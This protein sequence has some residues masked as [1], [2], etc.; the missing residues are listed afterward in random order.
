MEELNQDLA[1]EFVLLGEKIEGLVP[2]NINN[3]LGTAFPESSVLSLDEME[4][5]PSWGDKMDLGTGWFIRGVYPQYPSWERS[6]FSV[7]WLPRSGEVCVVDLFQKRCVVIATL[8]DAS[9][10]KMRELGAYLRS[11][12]RKLDLLR[13]AEKIRANFVR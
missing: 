7:Y 1:T 8:K 12:R 11:G 13:F 2:A 4:S 6:G 3:F 9:A 5:H 10:S